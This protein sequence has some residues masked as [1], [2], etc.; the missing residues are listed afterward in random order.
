MRMPTRRLISAATA[1]G[2]QG[3]TGKQRGRCKQE[4]AAEH[5]QFAVRQIEHAADAVDEHVAAGDQRVNRRQHHDI[6]EQL[7]AGSPHG[8]ADYFTS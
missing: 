6:D 1:D 2:D 7:H 5:H 4:I 3:L 8:W